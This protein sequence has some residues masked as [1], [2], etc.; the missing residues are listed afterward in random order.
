MRQKK[1]ISAA[2]ILLAAAVVLLSVFGPEQ[3]ARYKDRRTLNRITAR[4]DGSGEGY[5]YILSS[6]EKLFL[7]AECLSRQTLPESERSAMTRAESR[8]TDYEELL[9]TYAFVVNRQGPSGKEITEE[10]IFSVCSREL[11]ELAERGVIPA[12][13]KETDP[14][15]YSAVLYSAIDVLEPQNNLS[16]WKIS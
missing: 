8:D 2:V 9:G 6:N 12:A 5:R 14:D 16:V 3:M 4:E 13:V 1:K 10:E 11:E 7:L 15:S